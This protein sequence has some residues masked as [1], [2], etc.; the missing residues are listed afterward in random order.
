MKLAAIHSFNAISTLARQ[1]DI[2]LIQLHC[3]VVITLIV[4]ALIRL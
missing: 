3:N 4:R 2:Q 1:Q